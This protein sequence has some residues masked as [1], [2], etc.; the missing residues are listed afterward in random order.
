ML[1]SLRNRD[2][3]KATLQIKRGLRPVP[4][5]EWFTQQLNV[6][7]A[8]LH[9]CLSTTYSGERDGRT[10]VRVLPGGAHI[11][12]SISV[13]YPSFPFFHSFSGWSLTLG[14]QI[15]MIKVKQ[16]LICITQTL[17]TKNYYC[18]VFY[19]WDFS[20][21]GYF[22]WTEII[23]VSLR[24]WAVWKTCWSNSNIVFPRVFLLSFANC[25][26]VLFIQNP[27]CCQGQC[28]LCETSSQPWSSCTY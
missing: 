28:W 24:S 5:Q 11:G 25:F 1:E 13:G 18:I 14:L 8:H 17:L 22:F 6:A 9:C 4:I 27:T 26:L 23:C 19:L 7:F 21:V 12:S 20:P 16:W 3:L 15:Q 2:A 10:Q